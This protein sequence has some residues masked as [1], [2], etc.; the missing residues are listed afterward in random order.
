MAQEYC[1]L[2]GI[3][4]HFEEDSAFSQTNAA[5]FR[6]FLHNLLGYWLLKKTCTFLKEQRNLMKH[7]SVQAGGTSLLHLIWHF[8]TRMHYLK[9]MPHIVEKCFPIQGKAVLL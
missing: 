3:A 6:R 2:E 5:F 4:Y 1:L 7:A 9:L 8:R